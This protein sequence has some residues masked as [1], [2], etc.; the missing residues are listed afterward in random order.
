ME[1]FK[2]ITGYFIFILLVVIL[3]SLSNRYGNY[4]TKKFYNELSFNG[5]ISKKYINRKQHNYPILEIVRTDKKN[6]EIN[7]STDKSGLF[8]YVQ[9][10]DS[11]IKVPGSLDVHVFRNAKDTI[12]I[13]KWAK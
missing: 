4:Q 13:L 9:V 1:K 3:I 11:I 7:L 2:K 8:E 12:F 5:I 6:Q 10:K